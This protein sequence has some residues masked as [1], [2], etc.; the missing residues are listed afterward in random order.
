MKKAIILTGPQASGKTYIPYLFLNL[1][2]PKEVLICDFYS[3]S[4]PIFNL[5]GKKACFMDQCPNYEQ[6]ENFKCFREK[7][8]NVTFIFSSQE[9]ISLN[10]IDKSSYDLINLPISQ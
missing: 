1:L 9:N 10:D 2:K 3:D 8:P 5:K 4:N 6:I 7:H